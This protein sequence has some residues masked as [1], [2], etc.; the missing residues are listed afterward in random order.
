MTQSSP[1]SHAILSDWTTFSHDRIQVGVTARVALAGL[2]ALL[3]L[4]MSPVCWAQMGGGMGGGMGGAGGAQA[5]AAVEKARFRDHIHTR[6]GM[7]MRRERGDAIVASVRV[8]G[9][10]TVEVNT[11]AAELQTRKGRFYDEQTV[12]ADVRRL[13]DMGSF[14]QVTYEVEELPPTIDP[15]TGQPSTT[16]SMIVTFLVHENPMVTRVIFHGARALNVRELS[17]RVG[18]TTGDP[19]SRFSID[20]GRRRLID[21]YRGEGFN[22][23]AI[24][25]SIGLP[26]QGDTP[27]DPNAV[28]FRIN[29]G[30][31]ERVRSI[32]IEGSTVVSESRLK[33]II[34]SRGPMIGVLS[35]LG[36]KADLTKIDQDV[37]VLSSYYHN[38]GFLTATVGRRI[39]YDE[40]GK[41]ID[42]TF[43]INEGPRFKIGDVQVLGNT[44]VTEPSLRARMKLKTGDMFDG[45]LMRSDIGEVVYGY[46]ELG[47]IYAEVKPKTIMR[48][49]NGVV[50]LIYQITEGDRW[51]I[52]QIN[53]NIAGEPH[54]MKETTMLNLVDMREGDWIDRRTLELSRRRI[55][56]SQFLE[57][58]PMIAEAPDIKVVPREDRYR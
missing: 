44:F 52:G 49:E 12:L 15:Q 35:Y 45:T 55:E 28:I 43:V 31:K 46:G 47:F 17:G 58:N 36:N 50:D 10:Q 5:P 39:Q 24:E 19:L 21:Y 29:E 42:V 38:L 32:S 3:I 34:R 56:R 33:K 53:V 2:G 22:Q 40:T 6:A 18:V 9:N 26:A 20:S 27:A 11:I 37:D 14:D 8:R 41:W 25:S 51:K 1:S 54:L 4:A 48:D 30:P 7:A 23:V 16:K 57:T 13:Y